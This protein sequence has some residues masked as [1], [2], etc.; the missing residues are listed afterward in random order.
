LDMQVFDIASRFVGAGAVV[1][2]AIVAAIYAHRQ[3]DT[4]K[5]QAVIAQD[6]LALDLFQRRI[7]AYSIVR[8]AIG[9]ITRTGA[10]SATI[11][12]TLLEAIDAARFLFGS[13]VRGYLDRLYQNLIGLDYQNKVLSNP[14]A[15]A[16]DRAAAAAGRIENFKSLTRFYTDMDDLFGRYLAVGHIQFSRT[17]G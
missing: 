14:N 11:E 5:R 7:E 6:K 16:P 9:E 8:R 13:D 2:G 10:S 1:I 4:A 17:A 15:S 3:A 12:I